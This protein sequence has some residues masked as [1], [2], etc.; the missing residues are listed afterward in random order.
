MKK[1]TATH[2]N[3]YFMSL[4]SIAQRA[5]EDHISYL[6]RKKVSRFTL[7]E[8]L[9]VI[10]IIA[11]LAALLLPALNSAKQKA[12]EIGCKNNLKQFFH[13]YNLYLDSS[14]EWLPTYRLKVGH[15][16][17]KEFKNLLNIRNGKQCFS[18]PVD[19]KTENDKIRRADPLN[20]PDYGLNGVGASN[21]GVRAVKL[22]QS[23]ETQIE[24]ATGIAE[25]WRRWR[26]TDITRPAAC[27]VAGD[28]G[29]EGAYTKY[30]THFSYDRHNSSGNFCFMDGHIESAKA[31]KVN[32][33]GPSTPIHSFFLSGWRSGTGYVTP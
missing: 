15:Y 17:H 31:Q 33:F 22:H 29:R 21:Q 20:W 10:A 23:D 3:S 7:I 27:L 25:G 13:G 14:N 5:E 32:G 4:S 28:S 19:S 2:A 16:F 6:K 8:L 24:S 12:L 1:K 11:I 26:L 9:V 30:G 18:C